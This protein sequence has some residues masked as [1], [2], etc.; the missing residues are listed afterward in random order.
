MAAIL[1]REHRWTFAVMSAVC[2]CRAGLLRV[3]HIYIRLLCADCVRYT[4]LSHS[5]I[6]LSR[7]GLWRGVWMCLQLRMSKG[8]DVFLLQLHEC[9][10]HNRHTHPSAGRQEGR[11]STCCSFWYFDLRFTAPLSL[12]Q[13]FRLGACVSIFTYISLILVCANLLQK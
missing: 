12:G 4:P 2:F 5:P 6:W 13:I 9:D 3:Q 11:L 7:S 10:W 8:H 1:P